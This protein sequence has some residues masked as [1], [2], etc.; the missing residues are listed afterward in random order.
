MDEV[1]TKFKQ[2]RGKA[3]K[4]IPKDRRILLRNKKKL[5]TK[6]KKENI[7]IEKKDRIE[8]SIVEIDMK[9]LNSHQDERTNE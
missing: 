7:S 2:Q 6:L 4:I 9:L 5:S 8:K 1:C 3:I